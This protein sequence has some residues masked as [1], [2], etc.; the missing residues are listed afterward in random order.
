M[1]N[2]FV[3]E[4]E[5][6]KMDLTNF[7]TGKGSGNLNDKS[8]ATIRKQLLSIDRMK[9]IIPEYIMKCR[10]LDDFWQ[11]IKIKHS[12]YQG[13]RTYLAQTFTPVIEYFD[14]D[15]DSSKLSL[16]YE[17]GERIGGGGFGEVY[18]Y[19]H[20]LLDMD[21]AVKFFSP[22]FPV[23]PE[24]DQIRFFQEAKMLFE[25]NHESIISVYDIGILQNKPYIRM[26][27]FD[28]KNLNEV[29]KEFGRLSVTKANL[30]IY[31]ISKA[32]LYAHKKVVHRDLK[33]SNIMV[34]KP[35]RFKIID[36]GLGIYR[37]KQLCS[38]LTSVGN[39][40]AGG[41]YTA[42][43]L[44]SNP[45]LVDKRSDIYSIGAIWYEVLVGRPPSG[46]QM[47]ENLLEVEGV[48]NDYAAMIFKCLSDISLRY[49]DLEELTYDL[50][51]F[52]GKDDGST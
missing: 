50:S 13:R 11:F 21:F 30:L 5:N 40:V 27:Y 4:L 25:L 28:G 42:P 23:E 18:K 24:K 45:K 10:N 32:I 9:D 38:R 17:L 22:L 34:A 52:M 7:T 26:E 14:D 39:G 16:E 31:N 29:L 47:K 12:T 43:E 1:E 35:N 33:P 8:Y 15:L 19:H 49:N 48:N 46:S 3:L 41:L 20:K 44:L 51:K 36:F 6:F 2:N 37:E